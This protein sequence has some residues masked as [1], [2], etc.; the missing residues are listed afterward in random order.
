MLHWAIST[1]DPS[2]RNAAKKT[3]SNFDARILSSEILFGLMRN[4]YQLKL[5]ATKKTDYLTE[6]TRITYHVTVFH[7][8]WD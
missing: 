6:K 4:D 5:S 1:R 8:L 7:L 2:P 3:W